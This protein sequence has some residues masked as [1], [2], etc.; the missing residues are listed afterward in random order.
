[1]NRIQNDSMVMCG[2]DSTAPVWRF[3]Y[4]RHQW[5]GGRGGDSGTI[6]RRAC[7][8]W[9]GLELGADF[10][11]A[12]MI[13]CKY[14]PTYLSLPLTK[15]I[16]IILDHDTEPSCTDDT[17]Y[18]PYAVLRTLSFSRPPW[19]PS[20]R[21]VGP[22]A[23]M[24]TSQTPTHRQTCCRQQLYDARPL[25]FA[26]RLDQ[27]RTDARGNPTELRSFPHLPF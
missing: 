18:R 13:W 1:M 26:A 6:P 24:D 4:E 20:P 11:E 12:V 2:H 17:P 9:I 5:F 23:D 27:S 3:H 7:M 25:S 21:G 14:L 15:C 19:A 10:Y 16:I 8:G 22:V